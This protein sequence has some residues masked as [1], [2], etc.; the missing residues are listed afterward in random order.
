VLF[1][2]AD[3]GPQPGEGAQPGGSAEI[4]VHLEA[5]LRETR[6]RLQ[7]LIEEYETALEELKS[8]NEEL[9]SVNEEL[10]STNE[11]LEASK[12]ELQSVNEELHTVNAELIGKVEQLDR[13]NSDLHNLFE[14]TQVATVFLDSNLVIR[15]FTPAMSRIFHI[16]PGDRGRP[17]TDL[18]SR[19]DLPTLA[20]DV[21]AVYANGD[22]LERTVDSDGGGAHFLSRL[23]PYRD[24]DDRI[25]GVVATFVDV[26]GLTRAEA[27]K[28]ALIAELNHRVKNMLAVAVGIVEQLAKG[29]TDT[30]A[31]KASVID[32]LRAMAR[33]YALVAQESWTD[34]S[35]AELANLEFAP[36]GFQ[37]FILD[38]PDVRLPA[39][40]ALSLGMILH[41]L[42]TNAAKHGALSTSGGSVSLTWRDCIIADAPA[43]SVLWRETGG[44]RPN[45]S[46][47][48]FGR[49]L[50][51]RETRSGLGGQ[52]VITM[53][54][55][56]A[57]IEL[58]FPLADRS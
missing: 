55:Q 7:S 36:F 42:A 46:E 22:P 31:F 1:A 13:A 53:A 10:Q 24:G 48:G 23:A 40:Q 19:L 8:S 4:A 47:P 27:H 9:V 34:T 35:I 52:A 21:R 6:D 43:L 56:G 44:P 18:A 26:T 20:E 41:E 29:A 12:E 2:D 57:C 39:Q 5:E 54:E 32:R 11:E 58:S 16:R 14:S 30:A 33:A 50:I 49:G 51:E 45:A 17:L 28:Q 38:G 15:S 3:A 37:R 25:V